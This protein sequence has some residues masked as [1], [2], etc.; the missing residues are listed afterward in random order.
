[1]KTILACGHGSTI[2][3]ARTVFFPIAGVEAR[4]PRTGLNDRAR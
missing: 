4:S 3:H 2:P 1:M